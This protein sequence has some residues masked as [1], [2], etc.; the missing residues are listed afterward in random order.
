VAL[1]EAAAITFFVIFSA[2]LKIIGRSKEQ[3]KKEEVIL[4]ILIIIIKE[5]NCYRFGP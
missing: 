5:G 2:Y 1:P 3:N 4:I